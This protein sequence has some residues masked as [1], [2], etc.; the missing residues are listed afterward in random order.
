M[1]KACWPTGVSYF[2]SVTFTNSNKVTTTSAT[3]DENASFCSPYHVLCIIKEKEKFCESQFAQYMFFLRSVWEVVKNGI[4]IS[5]HFKYFR[6]V[7]DK[8]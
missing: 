7:A 3:S 2:S 6:V 8:L 5:I 1:R 4:N